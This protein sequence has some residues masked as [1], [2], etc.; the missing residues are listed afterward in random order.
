MPPRAIWSG[1]ISF[2]LVTV[3]V[4]VYT[5]VGRESEERID[6][7]LVHEKDGARIRYGRTC[8]KGHKDLDWDEIA[9]AYEY[10]KGKWVVITDEDLAALDLESLRTI[11]IQAFV[12]DEQIDPLFYDTPY[13]V[14]PDEASAKA[15][16]LIVDALSDEGLVGL[17]KVA[18]REREHLCVLRVKDKMLVLTTVHWPEEIREPKFDGL[19]K[20]PRIQDSERKMARSLIQN[21]TDDFKPERFQDEYHKALK[22]LINRKVKGQDIVVPARAE[23]PEK[24]TD[25]MEA[26]RASVDAAKRGR[27]PGLARAAK[28]ARGS[29]GDGDL[30]SLTKTDLEKRAK[31]LGVEGRSK[32]DKGELARAI[33]KAS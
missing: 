33:R 3:P 21:L 13:Y 7:H 1:A 4:K 27:K 8:E 20:R 25:L 17:A 22:K 2:G 16:Q 28:S 10:A 29:S 12:P 5:A 19:S 9:K 18:M 30:K 24:V 15:Y 32:M 14:V 31:K 11:D 26:L 6:L 23:E